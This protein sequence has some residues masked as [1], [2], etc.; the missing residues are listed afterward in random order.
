MKWSRL[1]GITLHIE[2]FWKRNGEILCY[3]I[4]QFSNESI[5]IAP[6]VHGPKHAVGHFVESVVETDLFFDLLDQ[7]NAIAFVFASL[8]PSIRVCCS[9][10]ERWLLKIRIFWLRNKRSNPPPQPFLAA[11]VC[12]KLSFCL[13]IKDKFYFLAEISH[14]D[15]F[16]C[17]FW[18]LLFSVV[19]KSWK[20]VENLQLRSQR[21]R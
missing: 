14:L 2:Y 16:S 17:Y 8:F 6:L 19:M 11:H 4:N 18:P 12:L 1:A 10:N 9:L 20:I 3:P 7:I 15:Q 21:G 13:G 5:P